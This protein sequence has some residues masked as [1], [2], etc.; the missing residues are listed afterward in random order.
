[1]NKSNL[2]RI[3]CACVFI[4]AWGNSHATTITFNHSARGFYG[5]YNGSYS[6]GSTSH[7]GTGVWA[8]GGGSYPHSRDFF[9]FN[10]GAGFTET[11][12]S[13]T[14]RIYNPSD[15]FHSTSNGPLTLSIYD[16]GTSF[17]T[18]IGGVNAS[19]TFNDL[20]TGSLFGQ[21]VVD[22]STNGTYVDINLT[23]A[24]IAA[25]QGSSGLLS[26]G[27][28]IEQENH[29]AD[30]YMFWNS[31]SSLPSTQL[32][33][34]LTDPAVVPVPATVWLFGSG[35]LGLIGISKRRKAV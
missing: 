7:Y 35:L 34:N 19:T 13:G 17:S 5:E 12:L 31:S 3:I 23:A 6:L 20:G 1:M 10:L 9:S 28:K 26:F 24:A 16:V 8:Q 29:F 33:L 4:V 22:V 27:G 14:L 32:V 2:L 25:L 11:I 30:R 15:G 18:L 21:R